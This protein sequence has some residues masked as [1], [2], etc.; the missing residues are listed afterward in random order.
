MNSLNSKTYCK[1]ITIKLK[2]L[3]YRFSNLIY[4]QLTYF[5]P[6]VTKN[7][8][9]Q[10]VY[11]QN[12]QWNFLYLFPLF[13]SVAT[14]VY[15]NFVLVYLSEKNEN[16]LF[17]LQIFHQ[18]PAS[19]T[20]QV[21]P[22]SMWPQMDVIYAIIVLTVTINYFIFIHQPYTGGKYEVVAEVTVRS[23]KWIPILSI[24]GKCKN[25]FFEHNL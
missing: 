5:N 20:H 9:K 16:H 23:S 18:N 14:A 22:Q 3:F 1:N 13:L 10:Q 15:G 4:A 12:N 6:I 24:S 19:L 17:K 21:L 11:Q 7:V 25:F 8:Q 2:Q